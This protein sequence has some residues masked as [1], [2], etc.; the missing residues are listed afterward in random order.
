MVDEVVPHT[1]EEAAPHMDDEVV[2]HTSEVAA[3]Q[4]DGEAVPHVR[5]SDGDDRGFHF[6]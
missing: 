2:P 6:L 3:P 4:M 5:G 1:S